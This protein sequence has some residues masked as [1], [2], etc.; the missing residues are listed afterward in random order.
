MGVDGTPP[1]EWNGQQ[2]ALMG[3]RSSAYARR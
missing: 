2:D 3:P 1:L